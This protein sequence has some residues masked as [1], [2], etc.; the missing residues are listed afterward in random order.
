ML[1]R[2]QESDVGGT[3]CERIVAANNSAGNA[4][5]CGIP[6]PNHVRSRHIVRLHRERTSLK[7]HRTDQLSRILS[8]LTRSM[9]SNKTIWVHSALAKPLVSQ[10][11]AS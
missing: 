6:A 5:D 10:T 3:I 1:S 4:S 11:A 7:R 9:G 8:D 2:A